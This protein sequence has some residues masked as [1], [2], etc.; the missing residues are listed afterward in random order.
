MLIGD[1][2]LRMS[3]GDLAEAVTLAERR[4]EEARADGDP[5]RWYAREV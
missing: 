4:V 3:A 1:V 5:T 2:A